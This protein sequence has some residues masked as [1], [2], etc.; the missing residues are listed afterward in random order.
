MCVRWDRL[1]VC[2]VGL[3]SS[4]TGSGQG[5]G[6]KDYFIDHAQLTHISA[7]S[8]ASLAASLHQGISP[9]STTFV[10]PIWS[11]SRHTVPLTPGPSCVWESCEGVALPVTIPFIEF[12]IPQHNYLKQASTYP[13]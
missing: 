9:L 7:V 5:A 12:A 10:K 4:S 3:D 2:R 13:P 11:N 6:D 1:R 8:R